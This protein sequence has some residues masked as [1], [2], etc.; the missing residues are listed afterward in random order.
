MSQKP[1]MIILNSDENNYGKNENLIFEIEKKNNIIEFAGE[2]EMEPFQNS[3]MKK[4]KNLW[5]T[6]I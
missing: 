1:L 4:L 6:S 2:F 5:K 3:P